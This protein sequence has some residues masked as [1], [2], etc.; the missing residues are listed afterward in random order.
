MQNTKIVKLYS[1]R[2]FI[3]STCLGGIALNSAV[4]GPYIHV[5]KKRPLRILGTHVTLQEQIR[6]KAMEE[7]GIE[8]IYEPG[9]DADVL[10]KA[11]SDPSSFDLYEQWT[12]SITVLWRTNAIQGIEIDRL[13]YWKEINQL[14][15]FG[16]LNK[17]DKIGSGDAPHKLLFIQDDNTL[18]SN[19]TKKISFLPY[20]HNVDSFGYDSR[21]IPKGTPYLTESWG[22]LLDRANQGKVGL[23]NSPTISIFDAALA[24]QAQGL[25]EFNDI[26]NMTREEVDQLFSILIEF[27]H[28]GHFSG[29]WNSVPESVDFFTSGRTKIASMFSPGIS[30][31]KGQ[32]VPIIYA[33]PKEGYR[34]WYGVMCM[35]SAT[36]GHV[37]DLAY[38]YMDWWLSGWPGAFVAKQG[39]YISNPQR[40]RELLSEDEWNYWYEGKPTLK[41]LKNTFGQNAVKAGESRNGGSYEKRFS[42]VAV[43][44]TVMDTYEYTLPR[45]HEFILS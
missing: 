27:K 9:G 10:Q 28:K 18:G 35:S 34:A 6:Q 30:M 14:A 4:A 36:E 5:Q 7:L 16:R 11:I 1:R 25:M 22:W 8:I 26:G 39:Y 29:L 12:D 37:K 13:L 44:N 42:N 32:G 21:F 31:L 24:A 45:W 23:V 15:K 41:P 38:R 2:K 3:K 19:F 40:S 33:A 20:V 43:W 17:T